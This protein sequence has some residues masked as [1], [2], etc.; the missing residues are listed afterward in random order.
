VRE[1]GQMET[2]PPDDQLFTE[3]FLPPR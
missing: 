3:A 2:L 1:L